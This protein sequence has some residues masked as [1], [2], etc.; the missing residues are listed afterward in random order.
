MLSLESFETA[1]PEHEVGVKPEKKFT[2]KRFNVSHRQLSTHMMKLRTL[3][4]ATASSSV[5]LVLKE[6]NMTGRFPA[7]LNAETAITFYRDW[8]RT[9]VEAPKL[10]VLLVALF[11]AQLDG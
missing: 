4:N 2:R 11:S 10:A 7:K 6:E 5:T 8:L 1:R 9:I 3:H